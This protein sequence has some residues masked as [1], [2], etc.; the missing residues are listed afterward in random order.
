M[1][2]HC[3]KENNNIYSEYKNGRNS[4]FIFGVHMPILEMVKVVDHMNNSSHNELEC[5]I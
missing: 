3:R 4:I 5:Q 1:E 2:L